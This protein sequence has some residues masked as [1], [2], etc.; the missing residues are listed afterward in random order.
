MTPRRIR[1]GASRSAVWISRGVEAV[2]V[3]LQR[4]AEGVGHLLPWRELE[5][6]ALADLAVLVQDVR[7]DAAVLHQQHA[8]L[9]VGD[10]DLL[11]ARGTGVGAAVI[12][13]DKDTLCELLNDACA[14]DA[15][16]AAARTRDDPLASAIGRDGAATAA[17]RSQV[18]ILT[19]AISRRLVAD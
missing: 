15:H 7:G 10:R 12:V 2:S 8:V 1:T 13:E 11:C 19:A 9:K 18:V 14:V 3:D 5:A 17:S 6:G 16:G 4:G